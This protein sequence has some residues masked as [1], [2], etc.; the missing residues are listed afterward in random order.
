MTDSAQPAF[1]VSPD[2]VRRLTESVEEFATAL[3]G[4]LAACYF[5][6]VPDAPG[7]GPAGVPEALDA[8]LIA[9]DRAMSANAGAYRDWA[10]RA[11]TATRAYE[12]ADGR[13]GW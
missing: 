5:T 10:A 6:A 2:E 9:A 11:R 13:T 12:A 1:E 4:D 8:W 3:T 7:G